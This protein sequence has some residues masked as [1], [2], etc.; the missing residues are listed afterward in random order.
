MQA[1]TEVT[2]EPRT[3]VP[4]AKVTV[5]L[6]SS[7][8]EFGEV[9]YTRLVQRVGSL[10]LPIIIPATDYDGRP[11]KDDAERLKVMG[12][13]KG[14]TGED[15]TTSEYCTRISGLMRVYFHVLKLR[16]SAGPLYK[17]FQGPR[18]WT[19]FARMLG[20]QYRSLHGLP[21]S[22]FLIHS[23]SGLLL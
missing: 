16:P 4:L 23:E 3:A 1:E 18:Y 11:W 15:E 2:A 7:I 5:G 17:M 14:P 9:L 8:Q 6:L 19:W 12:Y 13:R 10:A 20:G 21:A 22:A